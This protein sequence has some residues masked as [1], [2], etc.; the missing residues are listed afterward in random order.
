MRTNPFDAL[1]LPVRPDLTDEQVRA[2]WRAIATATHPD[3]ADGG[4]VAR[5]TAATAAYVTLRSEWGRSEAC[6]DV[7]AAADDTSP[8]PVV[9]A[10]AGTL[11]EPGAAPREVVA[12]YTWQLPARIRYG[13]PLRL[14]IR[15]VVA[16]LL[17]LGVLAAIPGDLAAPALVAALITW[18]VVTGRSDLAPPRHR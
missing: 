3:R 7:M 15:G 9:T 6:A 18:F 16:A 1:G 4:D 10:V 17:C 13:R 14:V 2:A 12:A 8:L 11:A 5:Y